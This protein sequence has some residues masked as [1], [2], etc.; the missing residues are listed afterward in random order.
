MKPS[1]RTVV[2]FSEPGWL[3]AAVTFVLLLLLLTYAYLGYRR[4]RSWTGLPEQRNPKGDDEGKEIIVVPGK[5]FWDWLQLLVIPLALAVGVF[6][7]NAYQLSRPRAC[8]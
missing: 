2:A 1:P 6:V 5:N 3:V 8:G 7:L 4:R